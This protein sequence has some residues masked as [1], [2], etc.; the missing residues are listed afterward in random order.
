VLADDPVVPL[1]GGT[2][3]VGLAGQPPL[4]PGAEGDLCQLW[5]DVVPVSLA[6]STVARNRS[7]SILRA[8][9]LLRW[10]PAGVR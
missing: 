1:V 10:E 2:F 8:N 3:E 4:G 7:A 5:V 9:D 6:L